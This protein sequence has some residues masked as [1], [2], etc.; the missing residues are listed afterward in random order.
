M[1]EVLLTAF[2]ILPCFCNFCHTIQIFNF[3]FA[4]SSNTFGSR[5]VF[6]LQNTACHKCFTVLQ[7]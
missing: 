4:S 7:L 5:M 6:I 2:C 1:E 3:I